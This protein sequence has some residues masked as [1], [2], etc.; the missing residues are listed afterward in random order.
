M[1]SAALE[2]RKVYKVTRS[3]LL[4]VGEQEYRQVRLAAVLHSVRW[5]RE[6]GD[7]PSKP[8]GLHLTRGKM[9]EVL[10][11]PLGSVVTM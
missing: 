3:A 8:I 10:C 11:S 6:I 4:V 1:G 9:V 2:R 5:F 7:A